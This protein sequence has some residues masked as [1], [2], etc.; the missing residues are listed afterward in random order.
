MISTNRSIYNKL[1]G[2]S[3]DECAP[4]T[5][6][7]SG[8]NA[9][10]TLEELHRKYCTIR[11][12][13]KL[14]K[15][16]RKKKSREWHGAVYQEVRDSA[17]R[18]FIKAVRSSRALYF[19]LRKRARTRRTRCSRSRAS[20]LAFKI[21]NTGVRFHQTFFG[22]KDNESITV[23]EKLPSL[24]YSVRLQRLRE[25]QYYLVIPRRQEWKQSTE[26]RVCAIDLGVR[27]FV[28]VYDPDSRT[29]S[30]KDAFAVIKRQFDA[31]DK[32]KSTLT[33]MDNECKKRH[34]KVRTKRRVL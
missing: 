26:R 31:I 24:K 19:A 6:K 5:D 1:I 28:T 25:G 34:K 7:E 13:S 2:Q 30:V 3:L 9:V 22:F 15:F 8:R 4:H 17:F 12:K 10:A 20:S 14:S 18:D 23:K 11:Q 21:M 29:V 16:F 33:K 32:M 27:N